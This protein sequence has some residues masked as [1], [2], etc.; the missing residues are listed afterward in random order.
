MIGEDSVLEEA[1]AMV[2]QEMRFEKGSELGTGA[3]LNLDSSYI[4]PMEASNQKLQIGA[5]D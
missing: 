1:L 5:Q 3:I 4:S 2:G